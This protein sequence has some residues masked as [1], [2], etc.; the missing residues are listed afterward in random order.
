MS[1]G[2]ILLVANYE[3]DVGYAWWLMERF[4]KMIAIE[5]VRNGKQTFLAYPDF[6]TKPKFDETL[7]INV[8]KLAIDL[9]SAKG[10]RQLGEFIKVNKISSIYLTDRPYFNVWYGYLR[11][12]GLRKIVVHDHTP[13]DRPK[14]RGMK[15][16]LKTVRNRLV[17]FVADYVINVSKLMTNRAMVNGCF[18]KRKCLTVQ[19]G[20][21]PIVWCSIKKQLKRDE[22][23]LD[24]D[25]VVVVTSGR[26]HAYKRVDFIIR[27]FSDV[28][29][30]IDLKSVLLIVGEGVEEE[31]L[32]ELVRSCGSTSQIKFLGFRSDVDDVLLASD[33]AF[34]ASKGEGFSLS[35]VEYM[36]A[37]LPVLVPSTPSVCQAIDHRKNGYI[38]KQDDQADAQL[39][40]FNLIENFESRSSLGENAKAKADALFSDRICDNQFRS[41]MQVIGW[42]SDIRI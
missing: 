5:Q 9:K 11:F 23:G 33:I 21:K 39:G 40:L 27:A 37:K 8:I 28:A 2:N 31:K 20:I 18:P 38:F 17:Y 29:K 7:G 3:P 14:I 22:L 35:V 10:I 32:R 36:S 30:R 19:N 13:G 15:R 12:K 26:L 4:W 6:L 42:S 34:H 41:A 25:T 24:A 1:D 16:L